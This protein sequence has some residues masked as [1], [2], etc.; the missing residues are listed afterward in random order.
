MFMKPVRVKPPKPQ[1]KRMAKV[2]FLEDRSGEGYDFK[3]G[4]VYEL[5]LTSCQRWVRRNMAVYVEEGELESTALPHE[6]KPPARVPDL[7]SELP[8]AEAKKTTKRK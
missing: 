1:P 7:V 2:R 3:A 6:P 4:Q 5:V 8:K